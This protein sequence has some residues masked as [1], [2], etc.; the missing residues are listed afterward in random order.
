M[1]RW[2]SVLCLSLAAC[3]GSA[4]PPAEAPDAEDATE[5]TSSDPAGTT[6]PDASDTS[7]QSSAG[8]A[9]SDASDTS[10]PA[11]RED[12]Q[13]VL[14]LVVEDPELEPFLKLEQPGRFPLRV[15]GLPD[16][17][18]ITKATKP[19]QVVDASEAKTKPVVVFTEI[20]V[21]GNRA[22]VRY[23][24]DIEGVRGACTLDKREGSWVLSKSRITER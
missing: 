11:S 16:G 3:G 14:Q 22:T 15:A 6:D 18:E 9:A 5:S 20:D 24:Y 23:R 4:T 2:L 21:Q 1:S 10:G 19:V 8:S 13:A 7:T 12:V 17:I